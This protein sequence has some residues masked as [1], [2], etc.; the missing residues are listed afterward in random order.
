MQAEE[1]EQEA[2]DMIGIYAEFA[3]S[4]AAMPVLVGRKS[5]MESFAGADC[6]YT[7]EA[8]MGD[9]RALQVSTPLTHAAC[10]PPFKASAS[11]GTYKQPMDGSAQLRCFENSKQSLIAGNCQ[12]LLRLD[13]IRKQLCS[14]FGC[15]AMPCLTVH[16]RPNLPLVW[17]H[18]C[19]S[20]S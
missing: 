10:L 14:K 6:T 5:R 3:R 9:R 11:N 7:I 4:V 2:R 18:G 17:Y 8:M 19:R 13:C 15:A 16:L 20:V 12:P 1:A